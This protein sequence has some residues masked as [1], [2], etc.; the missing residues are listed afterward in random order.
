MNSKPGGRGGSH[1]YANQ[2]ERDNVCMKL[3]NAHHY[4]VCA[5]CV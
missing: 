3:A 1:V 2:E 5:K 4:T